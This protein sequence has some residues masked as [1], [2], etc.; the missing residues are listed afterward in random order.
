[1]KA[2]MT[3]NCQNGDPQRWTGVTPESLGVR[4]NQLPHLPQPWPLFL[5]IVYLMPQGW[6]WG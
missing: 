5:V 6:E 4:T 1:M 3:L 2:A